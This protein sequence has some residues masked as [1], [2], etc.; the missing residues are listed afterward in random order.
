MPKLST[1]PPALVALLIPFV[2][3]R[4][5]GS[6][7]HPA[8]IYAVMAAIFIIPP[9]LFTPEYPISPAPL[10]WIVISVLAFTFGC[11]IPRR[12]ASPSRP[13]APVRTSVTRKLRLAIIICLIFSAVH[14]IL[15][16]RDF[17]FSPGR[18]LQ[19]GGLV[20]VS[21]RIS[22]L[23]YTIN[24]TPSALAQVLLIFV[25]LA[26]LI[27][28]LINAT[29]AAT[30]KIDLVV[31]YALL[32]P[33]GTVFAVQS[34]RAVVIIAGSLWIA[35]RLA[36]RTPLPPMS[37]ESKVPI[38]VSAAVSVF[39]GVVVLLGVGAQLRVGKTPTLTG[40]LDFA[41]T[42]KA[43]ATLL[44]AVPAFCY[45][46]D[47]EPEDGPPS[48]GQMTFAGPVSVAGGRERIEGVYLENVALGIEARTNVYTYYRGLIQ[49][50]TK[51]GALI[52]MWLLGAIM[53]W[54]YRS[55]RRGVIPAVGVLVMCYSFVI[56]GVISI[57]TYNSII[58]AFVLFGLALKRY[59]PPPTR[60]RA[61]ASH[62]HVGDNLAW[63]VSRACTKGR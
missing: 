27:G 10:W 4:V 55:A 18:L 21:M 16:V 19:S 51:V 8:L 30:N 54:A 63:A 15:L 50:Y 38:R 45:W 33:A 56:Y 47:S 5:S 32:V 48:W 59:Y 28:G 2:L 62:L 7:A 43:K 25:Y 14:V 53:G 40:I 52:F 60:G 22:A 49:D 13:R 42:D 39:A 24:P 61:R 12:A 26:A 6:F 57:F 31:S 3:R 44:G 1:V 29:R 58:A 9:V 36:A 11:G 35:S 37:R 20:D 17:G 23:R 46:F 34:T 41:V